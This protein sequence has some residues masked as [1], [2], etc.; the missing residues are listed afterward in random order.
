MAGVM[1]LMQISISFS[2]FL[3]I[4]SRCALQLRF[5]LMARTE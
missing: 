1:N 2:A 5:Y 3:F 4:R